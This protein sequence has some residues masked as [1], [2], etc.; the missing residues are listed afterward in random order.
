MHNADTVLDKA[1]GQEVFCTVE[2]VLLQA[3]MTDPVLTNSMESGLRK[4]FVSL[5]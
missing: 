2:T 4:A 3:L 5:M 1:P